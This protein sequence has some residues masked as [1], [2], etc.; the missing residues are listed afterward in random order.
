MSEV[1]CNIIRDMLPLYVD[2]VVS[3]DTRS[4]VA[5]HL[6]N[7]AACRG[8]YEI[9]KGK[10]AIPVER[11]VQPLRNFKRAWNRKKITLISATILITVMAL[12]VMGVVYT[13]VSLPDGFGMGQFARG[14][15]VTELSDEPF[16]EL[17]P[18]EF[19]FPNGNLDAVLEHLEGRSVVF[20]EQLGSALFFTC[21]G[22][23]VNASLQ[24]VTGWY[25]LLTIEGGEPAAGP[26]AQR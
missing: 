20:E 12:A 26:D 14:V 23:P 16:A 21:E 3:E 2:G 15:L 19:F 7:C 1:T 24:A 10:L 22:R 25:M 9:M 11:D 8:K 6:K 18:T 17:S 4:M 5:E 13:W